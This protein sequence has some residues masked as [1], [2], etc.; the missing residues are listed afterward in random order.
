MMF[1][2]GSIPTQLTIQEHHKYTW[3][4]WEMWVEI[5]I[6]RFAVVGYWVC[7]ATYPCWIPIDCSAINQVVHSRK[8]VQFI[9]ADSTM[10]MHK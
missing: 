7:Y 4:A 10:A 2:A 5:G 8:Q 1:R 9:S 6:S 3:A